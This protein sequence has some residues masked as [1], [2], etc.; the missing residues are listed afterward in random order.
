MSRVISLLAVSLFVSVSVL[1]QSHNNVTG[2]RHSLTT[3]QSP[4]VRVELERQQKFL[5][6]ITSR[7]ESFAA[8]D[9]TPLLRYRYV[10][11]AL[12]E[13][14]ARLADPKS[15]VATSDTFKKG[16]EALERD[17]LMTFLDHQLGILSEALDL[18]DVQLDDV[19]NA[20]IADLAGK[21]LLLSSKTLTDE[22]FA[23]KLSDLSE[24]TEKKIVSV[25]FADQRKQFYQQMYFKRDRLVG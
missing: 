7:Y 9:F 3:P 8:N 14:R 4:Q 22:G 15:E 21:R 13:N 16:Y 10:W 11:N 24:Q 25:L 18:N 20:L 1:A 17:V 5:R 6:G 12:R 23:R 19:R 2:R